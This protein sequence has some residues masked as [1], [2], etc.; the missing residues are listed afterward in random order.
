MRIFKK[1]LEFDWDDGNRGKNQQKHGVSDTECEEAFFDTNKRILAD[2]LHSVSESRY[3][4]LGS[5]QRR[6]KLFIA[7]TMRGRKIRVI[8]ARDLKRKEY[9]LYEEK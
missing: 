7:F 6:R 3:I 9:Y 2:L 8:S 5:T 1:P 4:L